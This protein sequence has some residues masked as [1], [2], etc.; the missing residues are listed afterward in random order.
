MKPI[1]KKR[2]K[3]LTIS[4]ACIA[5]LASDLYF[6]SELKYQDYS[7]KAQTVDLQESLDAVAGYRMKSKARLQHNNDEPIYVKIDQSFT[8]EQRNT[9]ISALDNIFGLVGDVNSKYKYKIVDEVKLFS[10]KTYISFDIKDAERVDEEESVVA[11]TITD[12]GELRFGSKG[13]FFDS[14]NIYYNPHTLE[15]SPKVTYEATL[16]ELLHVFGIGDVYNQ[17]A[18]YQNTFVNTHNGSAE[19]LHMITPND[20]KLLV[21][22]YAEDMGDMTENEK[23]KYVDELNK[24]IDEYSKNY[25][26]YYKTA[27]KQ[28]LIKSGHSQEGVKNLTGYGE[29]GKKVDITFAKNLHNLD[30]IGKVRI[31]ISD[32]KYVIATYDKNGKL[33]DDC[34]GKAHHLG[35]VIFL[36]D[37]HLKNFAFGKES[38]SDLKLSICYISEQS[39]YYMITDTLHT[40]GDNYCQVGVDTEYY[41]QQNQGM[42]K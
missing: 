16:H 8:D 37:V 21:S 27:Y 41:N 15:T 24:K 18:T 23:Q 28:Y 26:N 6:G 14:C 25:Y 19:W 40:V 31:K 4:F 17:E 42:V 20:Y 10:N 34:S 13:S 38:F 36:Q 7:T 32:D 12:T 29:I 2:I 3:N 22:M 35:E 1:I 5:V 39:T 9:I 33:I 30:E 11:T